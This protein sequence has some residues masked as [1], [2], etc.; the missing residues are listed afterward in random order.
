M[1]AKNRIFLSV[2]VVLST[3]IVA[4]GEY[5]P[6]SENAATDEQSPQLVQSLRWIYLYSGDQ[7]D[8][9]KSNISY[10]FYRSPNLPYKDSANC[11]IKRLILDHTEFEIDHV[12]DCTLSHKFFTEELS[13][14]ASIYNNEVAG[15]YDYGIWSLEIDTD[16][17]EKQ[18]NFIE[19]TTSAWSYTGGAHG[20][21]YLGMHLIDKKSGAGLSLTDFF[22]DVDDLSAIADPIFRES[23]GLI[24]GQD[25]QNAGFW[26]DDGVFRV[27]EN[28][29]FS[30]GYVHFLYNP[31][32]IGPYS[33]GSI[34]VSVPI[35]E[36]K[37]LL[38]RSID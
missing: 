5:K 29:S 25:L 4:C 20:N 26:F 6:I 30:G 37:H 12:T 15:G 11:L 9:M 38:I 36:V 18:E 28:F 32:E 14:F 1:E 23:Q 34:E 3:L 19:I 24:F 17:N 16:I 35:D 31:Y 13:A 8:S 27:N 21:G 22:S 33:A 2:L 10:Q 7:A